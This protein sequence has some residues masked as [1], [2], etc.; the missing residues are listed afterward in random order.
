MAVIRS[1]TLAFLYGV[2]LLSFVVCIDS[3]IVVDVFALTVVHRARMAPH[4]QVLARSWVSV[5]VIIVGIA[6]AVIGFLH[7]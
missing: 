7:G 1:R 2:F 4:F 3:L 6:V 5:H